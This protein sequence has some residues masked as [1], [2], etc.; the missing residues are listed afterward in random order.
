MAVRRVYVKGS[1]ALRFSG[2]A[3]AVESSTRDDNADE[4]A[5]ATQ[6]ATEPRRST[7]SLRGFSCFTLRSNL[8]HP[9]PRLNHQAPR[10]E[11]RRQQSG[12]CGVVCPKPMLRGLSILR[13]SRLRSLRTDAFRVIVACPSWARST[14]ASRRRFQATARRGRFEIRKHD[15]RRR[16]NLPLLAA[17]PP[18]RS[19]YRWA[20][21]ERQYWYLIGEKKPNLL[22]VLK[23]SVCA[24]AGAT[25]PTAPEWT[26]GLRQK[27]GGEEHTQQKS[28]SAKIAAEL[29]PP[30]MEGG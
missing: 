6:P 15:R 16:G 28:H 11:R 9:I 18:N 14:F 21:R 24:S 25:K 7:S 2:W 12:S 26:S 3:P 27:H 29:V 23:A 19:R 17:V 4:T 10:A 22:V 30:A 13:D 5:P 1:C 20:Y 8:C